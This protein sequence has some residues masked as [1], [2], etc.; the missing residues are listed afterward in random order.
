MAKLN[1]TSEKA[2]ETGTT[3]NPEEEMF[4]TDQEAKKAELKD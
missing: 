3:V 2:P 4:T 1:K